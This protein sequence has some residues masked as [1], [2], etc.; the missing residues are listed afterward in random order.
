MAYNTYFMFKV[1]SM[2]FLLKVKYFDLRK[3][4]RLFFKLTWSQKP[5]TKYFMEKQQHGFSESTLRAGS[6]RLQ[7]SSK[8][9]LIALQIMSLSQIHHSLIVH[10]SFS[11][12]KNTGGKKGPEDKPIRV[13][14]AFAPSRA[15]MVP[16]L[17]SNSLYR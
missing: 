7:K 6:D 11:F 12:R 5:K 1:G 16:G 9:L 4:S 17:H 15:K 14:A 10:I 13:V 3:S 8:S 2:L